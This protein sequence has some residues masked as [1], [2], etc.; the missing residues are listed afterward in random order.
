MLN[1]MALAF[2][3]LAAPPIH[4]SFPL[5]ERVTGVETIVEGGAER[6]VEFVERCVEV[7]LPA[8]VAPPAKGPAPL[9]EVVARRVRVRKSRPREVQLAKASARVRS[10][11]LGLDGRRVPAVTPAAPSTP[12]T[13]APPPSAEAPAVEFVCTTSYAGG[14][15]P[16]NGA[17]YREDAH[18]RWQ[19]AVI[20]GGLRREMVPPVLVIPAGTPPDHQW[21]GSFRR[22][23]AFHD[24][25]GTVARPTAAETRMGCSDPVVIERITDTDH[26]TT[27]T[28]RDVY[29]GGRPVHSTFDLTT[30]GKSLSHTVRQFGVGKGTP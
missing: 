24:L 15:P 26:G 13:P 29:C 23:E 21:K 10:F 6:R 22:D 27:Y 28:V 12:A 5:A 19:V 18:G 20:S 4:S 11:V 7:E 17:V 16:D 1:A 14:A 25:R 9:P 30:G 3:L 2:G 8:R